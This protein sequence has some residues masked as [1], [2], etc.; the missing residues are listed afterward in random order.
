M[1]RIKST[2]TAEFDVVAI[3]LADRQVRVS[4]LTSP[5]TDEALPKTTLSAVRDHVLVNVWWPNGLPDAETASGANLAVLAYLHDLMLEK[6][7]ENASAKAMA[8][9]L[10]RL[11]LASVGG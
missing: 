6:S 5:L 3:V 11:I 1:S 2:G 4:K 7:A 8:A 10:A 9:E